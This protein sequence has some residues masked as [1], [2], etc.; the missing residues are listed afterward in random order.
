M[1]VGVETLLARKNSCAIFCLLIDFYKLLISKTFQLIK[2]T[3]YIRMSKVS[4]LEQFK[5]RVMIARKNEKDF[6]LEYKA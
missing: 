2:D 1:K 3:I 5:T 6:H 4:F